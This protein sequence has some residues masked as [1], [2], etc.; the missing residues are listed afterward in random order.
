MKERRY[1][2]RFNL[3]LSKSIPS[4]KQPPI[5]Y[6]LRFSTYTFPDKTPSVCKVLSNQSKICWYILLECE[7]DDFTHLGSIHILSLT[8]HHLF[9]RSFPIKV[10]SVG[11][12]FWNVNM[13]TYSWFGKN[14]TPDLLHFHTFF[15]TFDNPHHKFLEINS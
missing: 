5:F 3:L 6:I 2:F 9:A 4:L 14:L 11:I 15:F 12:F 13:T 7:H 1:L 10:K 8:K